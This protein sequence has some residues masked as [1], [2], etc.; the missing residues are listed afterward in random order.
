[1]KNKNK[2][3]GQSKQVNHSKFTNSDGYLVGGVDVE[4]SMK[5]TSREKKIS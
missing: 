4:M 2:K 1:M 5:Y 3:I